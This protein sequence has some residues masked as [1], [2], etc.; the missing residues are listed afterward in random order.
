MNSQHRSLA[1]TS[2]FDRFCRTVYRVDTRTI[3]VC[4]PLD[5]LAAMAATVDD[6]RV[7]VQLWRQIPL[8]PDAIAVQETVGLF[9]RVSQAYEEN[10]IR[11]QKRILHEHQ[12]DLLH[13]K[14]QPVVMT[15]RGHLEQI[16]YVQRKM[17]QQTDVLPPSSVSINAKKEPKKTPSGILGMMHRVAPKT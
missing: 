11:E 13:Q 1:D 3:C 5:Q 15:P 17:Q 16:K 8:N 7:A 9:C 12:L 2:L 10:V 6:I 14:P 4:A